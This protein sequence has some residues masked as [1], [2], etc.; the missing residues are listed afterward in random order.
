MTEHQ[1]DNLPD[2][3][4]EY[5]YGIVGIATATLALA[6][7]TIFVM[8]RH[9]LYVDGT[10]DA[11]TKVNEDHGKGK[12]SESNGWASWVKDP[13]KRI[14]IALKLMLFLFWT[15]PIGEHKFL[16]FHCQWRRGYRQKEKPLITSTDQRD[17]CFNSRA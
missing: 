13:A 7:F 16:E 10:T 15:L 2:F 11:N 14:Q 17:F 3:P 6:Q 9:T 8:A 5:P 4:I 1:G 12:G